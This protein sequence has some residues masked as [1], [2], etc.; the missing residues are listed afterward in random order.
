M[1]LIPHPLLLRKASSARKRTRTS[2]SVARNYIANSCLAEAAEAS[3][4]TTCTTIKNY[5][6]KCGFLIH[7]VSW[8]D[9]TTVKFSEDSMDAMDTQNYCISGF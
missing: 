9:N 2:G 6:V 3:R 8:N 4:L 1:D 7:H 5:F